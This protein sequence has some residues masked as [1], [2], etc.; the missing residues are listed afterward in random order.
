ML[1]ITSYNSISIGTLKLQSTN[2][3]L[4]YGDDI[5][6]TD[7]I[8]NLELFRHPCR[9]D[10][11]T[12]FVCSTGA[13]DCSVNLNRYH[14]EQYT[15]LVA[16]TGDI[17]QIHQADKVDGYAVVISSDY[18]TDLQIDFRRR[19]NFLM[20][21]RSNAIAQ[22][23][24]EEIL[25]LK[26]YYNLLA[27]NIAQAKNENREILKGLIRAFSYTVISL[28]HTYQLQH[29]E[30]TAATPRSQQ[31]YNKFMQLLADNHIRERSVSYYA[32]R[33][34]LTPNYF[35]GEIKAYSGRTALDWINEHVVTEAKLMLRNP[36]NTIQQIAYYLN[37]PT[38]S[39]FGK[40]FRSQ[41]GMSPKE[42][43]LL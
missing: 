1:A 5:L 7:H 16:F 21:I 32:E 30:N 35:S 29:E 43:R 12:V 36:E 23:P 33:L 10:A 40:Y 3:A 42:Y 4:F 26:P 28:I 38:Q 31:L 9:L 18:L 13:V 20:D 2:S 6:I 15:I 39:A 11:T 27:T 17:I 19:T 25:Q 41:T 8:D 34:C 14:L 37:F 24:H 22:I